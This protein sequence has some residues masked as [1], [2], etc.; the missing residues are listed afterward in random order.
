MRQL[1]TLALVLLVPLAPRSLSGTRPAQDDD[2][3]R[4]E[5]PSWSLGVDERNDLL[6]ESLQGMWQLTGIDNPPLAFDPQY[7]V[8]NMLVH[9]GFMS[10][11]IHSVLRGLDDYD[12]AVFQTGMHRFHLTPRGTLVTQSMIGTNN[13][14]GE[15]DYLAFEYPG[16]RREFTIIHSEDRVA[17]E[18][19]VD[20]VRLNFRRIRYQPHGQRRDFFGRKIDE[21]ED[22]EA[23]D[24]ER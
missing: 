9:E 19:V 12:G 4:R 16:V 24:E 8:G 18:R 17:L 2:E 3:T 7:T 23:D 1:A 14:E 13:I 21:A 22:P 5:L 11:E 20:H 15:G 6:F 10:L